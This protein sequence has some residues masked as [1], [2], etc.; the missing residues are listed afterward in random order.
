MRCLV[1]GG[2]GFLGSHL[3]EA[4][5][6][7]SHDVRVLLRFGEGTTNIKHLDVETVLGDV[8]CPMSLRQAIKNCDVVYHLAG[9]VKDFGPK[10]AFI[11]VNL[12]GTKALLREACNA[13]CR[14]FVF[15][16]SLA[17]HKA[18]RPISQGDENLPRDNHAMP[19]ALSKILA[20]DAVMQAHHKGMIEGVIVRPAL[21]P[22]GERDRTSFLPLVQNLAHYRHIGG[23]NATFCA[24]YA[25]NLA[26]GLVLCGERGEASG[27]TFVLTDDMKIT[28]KTF[29]ARVCQMMNIPP[30][31]R[32]VPVFLARS[33]ALLSEGLA[34]I[35]NQEPLITRYRVGIASQDFWFSCEHAKKTL[36][37]SPPFGFEEG[38]GR[39]VAWVKAVHL[40]SRTV[41]KEVEG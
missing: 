1:T 10:E 3:V 21:F 38:L 18:S 28:W 6:N 37:Y 33:L 16:S 25:K 9:V 39:T 8:C 2:A 24:V 40:L 32:T 41:S 19:Y 29:I 22:Y 35:T 26:H 11:R 14:R 20:E 17:V 12:E 27:G 7:A 30:I 15:V 31:T 13:S 34:S 5:L 36:G 4:L 23:G